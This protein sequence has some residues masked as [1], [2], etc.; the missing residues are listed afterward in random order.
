MYLPSFI[1]HFITYSYQQPQVIRYSAGPGVSTHMYVTV[2]HVYR[3]ITLTLS[4]TEIVSVHSITYVR[5]FVTCVYKA[6]IIKRNNI[7]YITYISIIYFY[8]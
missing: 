3:Q 6:L 4:G 7:K 1:N 5:G 2:E 8:V